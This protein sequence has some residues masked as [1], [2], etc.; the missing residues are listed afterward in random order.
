MYK[1]LNKLLLGLLGFCI[2]LPLIFSF[3]FVFLPN[4]IKAAEEGAS[5]KSSDYCNTFYDKDRFIGVKMGVFVPGVTTVVTDPKTK[6]KFY[7]VRDLSCWIANFY[8]YFASAIAIIA[9][10]MII[11]GGFKYITSFG[12]QS[13]ITSAKDTIMSAIVGLFITLG[14]FIFL[15]TINPKIVTLSLPLVSY[16]TPE[17]FERSYDWEDRYF[18]RESALNPSAICGGF[19]KTQKGFFS[20]CTAVGDC[21]IASTDPGVCVAQKFSDGTPDVYCKGGNSKTRLAIQYPNGEIHDDFKGDQSIGC[22]YIYDS[23]FSAFGTV[24]IGKKRVIGTGCPDKR[25][26]CIVFWGDGVYFYQE[27]DMTP[28]IDHVIGAW[29][30]SECY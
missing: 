14:T 23:L 16:I 28:G 11:Y 5:L 10:V 15:Y 8:K 1:N 13:R 9:A 2:T 21:S 17:E 25:Q 20:E 27:G 22:G 26:G 24:P 18:C 12:N 30:N 7:A 29:K 3:V 19:L 6:E 4:E